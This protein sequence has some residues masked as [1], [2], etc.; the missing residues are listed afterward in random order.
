MSKQY[1]DRVQF[2]FV[3][4]REA[5]PVDGWRSSKNDAD[6]VVLPIARTG[7]QKTDHAQVC[8]R[9]LD[10]DFPTLV[11][12]MGNTTE[13]AYTAWPDRLYLVNR[14]G[15]IAWKGGIGPIGLVPAELDAA[16]RKEL[17]R[18]AVQ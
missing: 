10:I 12:D 14:E 6:G 15:R 8:V 13:I 9:A 5:H 17:A 1:A 18:Q 3:Y 7:E 16:I 4:I 2:L 11:D